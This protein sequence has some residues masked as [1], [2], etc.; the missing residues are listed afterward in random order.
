MNHKFLYTFVDEKSE[1]KK[2]KSKGESKGGKNILSITA[3]T[4]DAM[5]HRSRNTS[6]AKSDRSFH[7]SDLDGG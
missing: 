4:D 2:T 1:E 5:S 7:S 3:M 6:E